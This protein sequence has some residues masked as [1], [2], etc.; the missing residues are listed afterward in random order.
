MIEFVYTWLVYGPMSGYPKFNVP[1]FL[2]GRTALE[3]KGVEVQL[4][5]DLDDPKVV[6][7]LLESEDGQQ[8]HTG[9]TWGDC[10]AMDVKLIADVVDGVCVLPGW[11]NSR[12]ARLETFVAF[13]CGKK[14]VHYPTLNSVRRK[15]LK[16]AW[17]GDT[18]DG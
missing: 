9:L 13:L 14:I 3:A 7:R 5:A 11:Q 15:A 2:E 8:S 16:R 17:S 1:A 18:S 6:E 4:P 10:L 12:G